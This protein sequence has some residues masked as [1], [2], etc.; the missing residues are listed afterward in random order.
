MDIERLLLGGQELDELDQLG[1]TDAV[2]AVNGQ[3][4]LGLLSLE[5]RLE[6]GAKLLIVALLGGSPVGVLGALGVEAAHHVVQLRRRQE[7]IVLDLCAR[8]LEAVLHASEQPG[9]RCA[10][11]PGHDD[12]RRGVE[13]NFVF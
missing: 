1:P 2:G 7:A 3:A 10:C 11:V 12:A 9:A 6:G 5:R 8:R 4:A 13:V